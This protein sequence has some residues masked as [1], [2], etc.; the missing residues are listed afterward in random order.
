MRNIIFGLI[1]A[2]AAT[3]CARPSV[4]LD[5]AMHSDHPLLVVAQAQPAPAASPPAAPASK[6]GFAFPADKG[7]QALGQ[8]LRPADQLPTVSDVPPG[9]RPLPPPREVAFPA[10]SLPL[11]MN[12]AKPVPPPA[13]K[14][15]VLQPR[16]LPEDAPLARQSNSPIVPALR[17]L[18]TGARVKVLARDGNE[19]VALT[20]LGLALPDRVPLDDPTL[21]ASVAIAL[22]QAPPARTE[23]V[24]FSPMNLP[25][26][27]ANAQTVK[28]RTLPPEGT[29]PLAGTPKTPGK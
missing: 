22:A 11:P 26:P 4:A 24:P 25:D 6:D 23:P 10:V 9:P 18:E 8:L 2:G 28:L 12:A 3:G 1:L 29:D 7:G 5:G 21:E 16:T 27:F 13:G 20:I 14:S 17:E 15:A 19:P